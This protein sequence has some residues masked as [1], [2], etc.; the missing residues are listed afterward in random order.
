M[1]TFWE[2]RKIRTFLTNPFFIGYALLWLA[3]TGI[4]V[5]VYGYGPVEPIAVLV[6]FGFLLPGLAL[7]LTRGYSP[8][9]LRIDSPR[10]ETRFVLAYL[11]FIVAFLGWGL[12]L[13]HA[14]FPDQPANDIAVLV[15][16]VIVFVLV[17]FA[18]LM[19]RGYRWKDFVTARLNR[20]EVVVAVVLS[21]A[22][23]G[24][25]A[26]IGQGPK[27][28]AESGFDATTILVGGMAVYL[29]LMIEVGLVEEFFFRSLLQARLAAW[30]KSNVSGLFL[31]AILFGIAHA[32]GFY[33]RWEQ[34]AADLFA[35]P[36]LLFALAYS[37]AVISV[38]GVF[39]GVV[40]LRTRS[41]L[42]VI[43]IHAA[44]DWLPNVA[45]T[46]KNWGVQP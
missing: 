40:W 31:A 24:I 32:P 39:M 29:F 13:V 35:E 43:L 27:R 34:N 3:S 9:P 36:S 33:L 37:I 44:G 19:S 17:P 22:F 1:N 15:A 28:I 18:L 46:L 23:I 45:E 14:S 42:V 20:R 11:L 7:L 6:I 30:L 16:K 12:D 38:A 25:N 10:L 5:G 26:L 21:L 4:L 8:R 41:L 2:D